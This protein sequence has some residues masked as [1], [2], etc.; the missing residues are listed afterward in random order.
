MLLVREEKKKNER[1]P[2]YQINK[3]KEL[4]SA[5]VDVI[6]TVPNSLYDLFQ[7][8]HELCLENCRLK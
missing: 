1:D 8:S 5:I 6:G 2:E 4:E 3:I 7:I